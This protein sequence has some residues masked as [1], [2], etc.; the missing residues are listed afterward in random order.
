MRHTQKPKSYNYFNTLSGQG[1]NLPCTPRRISFFLSDFAF[2]RQVL[3]LRFEAR[4]CQPNV[5]FQ[6]FNVLDNT[7]QRSQNLGA[8]GIRRGGKNLVASNPYSSADIRSLVCLCS[9]HGGSRA[10][11]ILLWP[12]KLKKKK[13]IRS[14][15]RPVCEF[16]IM[17]R[18]S[19]RALPQFPKQGYLR[20]LFTK[21]F[22]T[23]R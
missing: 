6:K 17:N 20:A 23:Y 16:S 12:R 3:A 10:I 14:D 1:E 15:G 7:G 13:G 19:A 11:V 21:R 5:L 2:W 22:Y 4:W 8:G 18:K 9:L